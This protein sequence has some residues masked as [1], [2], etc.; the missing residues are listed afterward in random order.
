MHSSRLTQIIPRPRTKTLR[1]GRALPDAA[2]HANWLVRARMGKTVRCCARAGRT[3]RRD[4]YLR[5]KLRRRCHAAGKVISILRLEYQQ[6]GADVRVRWSGDI[7]AIAG[8]VEGARPR[9]NGSG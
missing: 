1:P 2:P 7:D 5:G 3:E 6:G 9:S 8:D 4:P